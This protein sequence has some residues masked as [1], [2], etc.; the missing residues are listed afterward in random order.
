[1]ELPWTITLIFLNV[2][3]HLTIQTQLN[4]V[5][6]EVVFRHDYE[7]YYIAYGLSFDGGFGI[8]TRI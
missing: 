2:G 4:P 1:M 3:L 8:G 5:G 6:A 7:I